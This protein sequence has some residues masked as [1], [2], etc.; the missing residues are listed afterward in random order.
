MQIDEDMDKHFD[1]LNEV[2]ENPTD[3]NAVVARRR[4]DFTGDF[5]RFLTLLSETYDSLDDRDG[6]EC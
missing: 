3:L 5:F 6:N 1:L 2:Q 4:R